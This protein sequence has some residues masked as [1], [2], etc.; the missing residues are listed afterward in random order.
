MSE[1]TEYSVRAIRVTSCF[2]FHRDFDVVIVDEAHERHLNTDLALGLL[3]RLTHRRPEFRL[4]IMSATIDL[5]MFARYFGGCPAVS[6]PG[7]LYPI[8][9]TYLSGNKRDNKRSDEKP[10][11]V[12]SNPGR[13]GGS[14]RRGH[15]NKDTGE[16]FERIDPHPYLVLLQV[17]VT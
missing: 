5:D 17:S 14:Y 12:G 16:R 9:L 10:T 7:R 15:R 4:V 8:K 2:H 3:K 11:V 1:L 13:G 6:V